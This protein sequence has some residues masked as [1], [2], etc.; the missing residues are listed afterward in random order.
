LGDAYYGAAF[1]IGTGG[2][3][4]EGKQAGDN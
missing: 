2:R 3:G 1:V 4:G